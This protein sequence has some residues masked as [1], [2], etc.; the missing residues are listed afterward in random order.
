MTRYMLSVHHTGPYAPMDTPE[1]QA[2]MA[3]TGVFT[4]KLKETGKWVF[5]GGL[6]PLD[7]ATKVDGRDGQVTIVDGAFTESKE[8]LG[9]FWVVDADDLDE[10]LELGAQ[11]SKA[12][13][14]PIV[15]RPFHGA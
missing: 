14:D 6:E 9:G 2:M 7:T 15:V 10:A 3:A 11:A 12:C 13:G 4:E 5:V 8:Y 1:A